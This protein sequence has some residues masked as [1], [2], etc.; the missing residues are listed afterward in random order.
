MRDF[1]HKMDRNNSA[2]LELGSVELEELHSRHLVDR[3][4]GDVLVEAHGHE[5]LADV[6]HG[7]VKHL[8]EGRFYPLTESPHADVLNPRVVFMDGRLGSWVTAGV[9]MGTH[10]NPEG[11]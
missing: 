4:L 5:Q 10:G 7:P 8:R 11:E 9:Q 6:V 2:Y 1:D 3:E